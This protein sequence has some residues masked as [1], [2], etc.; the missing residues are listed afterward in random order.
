M[1]V[2][3]TLK[4]ALVMC[5]KR[6]LLQELE[7]HILDHEMAHSYYAE[8]WQTKQI[9]QMKNTCEKRLFSRSAG[10]SWSSCAHEPRLG[11]SN[12]AKISDFVVRIICASFILFCTVGTTRKLWK[13]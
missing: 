9:S 7:M 8:L 10:W 12:R 4:A 2:H 1:N 5:V 11:R 13:Y 6:V 3:S